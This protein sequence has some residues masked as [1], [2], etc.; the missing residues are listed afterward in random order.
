MKLSMPSTA[1]CAGKGLSLGGFEDK[2]LS[3]AGFSRAKL[4]D[5]TT[6]VQD[7]SR[8]PSNV[9]AVMTA[10]PVLLGVNIPPKTSTTLGSLELQATN[11]RRQKAQRLL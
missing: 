11:A 9:L 5:V 1:K 10:V 4:L 2:L 7:V 8:L 6:I 3:V